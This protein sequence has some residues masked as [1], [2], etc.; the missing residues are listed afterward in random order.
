MPST[1]MFYMDD[2]VTITLN[3]FSGRPNPVWDL[4]PHHAKA[5]LE[6]DHRLGSAETTVI[7]PHSGLDRLGYRGFLASGVPVGRSVGVDRL[8]FLMSE[9][10]AVRNRSEMGYIENNIRLERW[11]LETA[12]PTI[13]RDLR[14]H[15]EAAIERPSSVEPV[16]HP[17]TDRDDCP[18]CRAADAPSYNLSIWNASHVQSTNNCYNYANDRITNTFAQPGKAKGAPI[19]AIDCSSVEISAQAD[20]LRPVPGFSSPL[21]HGA[22]WYV[23]LVVWP[24]MDHHWYAQDSTGCWSHKPGQTPVL[25]T[26]NSG[27]RIRDPRLCDRGPYTDFCT[28]MITDR[29]VVIR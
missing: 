3:V 13:N 4:K 23:A 21:G 26:D 16:P 17:A 10:V 6:L 28:Y 8:G 5:F 29:T 25:N 19:A 27:N 22:G 14:A 12:G 24:G 20:G 9:D 15:V 1:G 7:V 2:H 11:L 18:P